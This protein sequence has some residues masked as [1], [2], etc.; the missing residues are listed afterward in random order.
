MSESDCGK[1]Y[2][3]PAQYWAIKD[4]GRRVD[5]ELMTA[6][7]EIAAWR[8]IL[9]GLIAEGRVQHPRLTELLGTASPPH[10]EIVVGDPPR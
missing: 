8:S 2:V 10:F 5:V 3:T 9:D 7:M 1:L 6:A 4:L